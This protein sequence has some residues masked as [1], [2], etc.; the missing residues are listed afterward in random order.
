MIAVAAALVPKPGCAIEDIDGLWRSPPRESGAWITV[1]VG[2]CA[3]A[4]AQRC[5]IV[6]GAYDGANPSIVGDVV[7]RGLELQED[8]SWAEGKI[9]RPIEGTAYRSSVRLAGPDVIRV[10]GCAMLGLICRDQTW[11]RTE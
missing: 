6:E 4:P 9:V 7:L 2:P 5:G 3:G 1:R 10:E 8:G 11:T